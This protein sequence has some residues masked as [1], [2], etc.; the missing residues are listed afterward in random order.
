MC[1]T[2]ESRIC[3]GARHTYIPRRDE[4]ETLVVERT[5]SGRCALFARPIGLLTIPCAFL[6]GALFGVST[7]VTV[8]LAAWLADTVSAERGAASSDN[9][10]CGADWKGDDSVSFALV[11]AGSSHEVAES[12]PHI[13][14]ER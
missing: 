13:A 1:G 6:R 9:G 3:S 8:I 12:V 10:A 5:L 14:M 7:G 2:G 11:S 4:A